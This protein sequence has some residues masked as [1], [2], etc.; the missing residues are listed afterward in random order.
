VPARLVVGTIRAR[1]GERHDVRLA[2]GSVIAVAFDGEASPEIGSDVVGLFDPEASGTHRLTLVHD[3]TRLIMSGRARIVTG[4]RSDVTAR[5][6]ARMTQ[7]AGIGAITPGT[8]GIIE[9]TPTVEDPDLN[10]ALSQLAPEARR[11]GLGLN[12]IDPLALAKAPWED[13]RLKEDL[14]PADA[15]GDLGALEDLR[16]IMA[17]GFTPS[18][19]R[20]LFGLARGVPV[21]SVDF[22]LP[23]SPFETGHSFS[24][25]L[26]GAKRAELTRQV[27]DGPDAR[28]LS[29]FREIARAF[30]PRHLGRLR[31]NQ[32][33][34]SHVEATFADVAAAL[35]FL[36]SGGQPSV[37]R[38]LATL[39]QAGFSRSLQAPSSHQALQTVLSVGSFI[40]TGGVGEILKN[41][42]SLAKSHTPGTEEAIEALRADTPEGD[43]L[44]NVR[45]L[46]LADRERLAQAY[47]DDCED[48]VARVADVPVAMERMA[49]FGIRTVPLGLDQ[50]F[51]DVMDRMGAPVTGFE[52]EVVPMSFGSPWDAPPP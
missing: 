48:A 11:L 26:A 13:R 5:M 39:R 33:V 46:G 14:L 4:G 30:A 24:A 45:M 17:E 38:N 41:A 47:A 25:R 6:L 36:A 7:N 8:G 34:A 40:S 18:C 43:V 27:I 10:W 35:A 15:A 3:V 1:R 16:Q 51:D 42:A 21:P 12:V 37:I 23:Y 19:R 20:T 29:S 44:Y 52:D 2:D 9:R 50:A 32:L 31:G 28:R 22:V 49:R